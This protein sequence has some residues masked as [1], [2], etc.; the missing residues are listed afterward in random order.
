MRG[1]NRAVIFAAGHVADDAGAPDWATLGAAGIPIVLYMGMHNLDRIVSA[2]IAA[3]MRPDVPAA[4]IASATT[5]RERILVSTVG[6]LPRQ[7]LSLNL[8]PPAIVAIGEIVSIR[9]RLLSMRESGH[10]R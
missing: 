6:E 9:R 5:S 7:A 8:K 2:F 10:D 4:I 1:V 3:G